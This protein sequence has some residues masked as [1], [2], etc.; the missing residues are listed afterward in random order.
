[1]I[2]LQPAPERLLALDPCNR[3]VG[4]VVLDAGS[5]PVDWGVH[6]VSDNRHK[7]GADVIRTLIY[8][9]HPDRIVVER[10][11]APG[12]RRGACARNFI[13]AVSTIARNASIPVS[14]YTTSQVHAVFG[15]WGTK[16]KSARA[17]LLVAEFPA[18]RLYQPPRRRPW[19]SEDNRMA[20]F[21]AFSFAITHLVT[22]QEQE[23]TKCHIP[24]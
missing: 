14:R 24:F 21:D 4:F 15:R 2:D 17:A 20:I 18:L 10:M 7:T 9:Y 23:D 6:R 13:K 1:M 19:M 3:G 12:S 8:R 22:S 11:N 16:K 5:R